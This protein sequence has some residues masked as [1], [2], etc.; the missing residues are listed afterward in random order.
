MF[1]LAA[2]QKCIE[3]DMLR[4]KDDR[5]SYMRVLAKAKI[6]DSDLT[7]IFTADQRI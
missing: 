2:D 4:I 6:R 5:P 7:S 1:A 3:L